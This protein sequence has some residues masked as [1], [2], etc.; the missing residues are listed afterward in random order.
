M[1]ITPGHITF[2][3]GENSR[4]SLLRWLWG[5]DGG[6]SPLMSPI[7]CTTNINNYNWWEEKTRFLKRFAGL[8]QHCSIISTPCPCFN[9]KILLLLLKSSRLLH[10]GDTGTKRLSRTENRH[11][12][13]RKR[14]HRRMEENPSGHD[15]QLYWRLHCKTK[16]KHHRRGWAYR[17]LL[18]NN[19]YL[20]DLYVFSVKI[21]MCNENI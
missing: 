13:A 11:N 18:M 9:W 14:D 7:R 19:C 17:T 6:V 15:K 10:P 20:M 8:C 5:G 16:K 2:T 21:R 3:H 4:W 12:Y 1:A